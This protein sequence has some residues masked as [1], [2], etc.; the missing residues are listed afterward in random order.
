MANSLEQEMIIWFWFYC[1]GERHDWRKYC[2]VFSH[3]NMF[4]FATEDQCY[5]E[6]VSQMLQLKFTLYDLF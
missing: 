6:F 2:L 5:K 4:H 1:F 3:G